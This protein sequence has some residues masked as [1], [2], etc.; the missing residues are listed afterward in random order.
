MIDMPNGGE[1]IAS[2]I[3]EIIIEVNRHDEILTQDAEM[4]K[5]NPALQDAWE[6]YQVI[7]GLSK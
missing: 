1:D 4:R 2:V 5:Q 3:R 7:K 6:Q